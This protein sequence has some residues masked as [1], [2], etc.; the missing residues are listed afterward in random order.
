M[1][2]KVREHVRSHP[3]DSLTEANYRSLFISDHYFWVWLHFPH[4]SWNWKFSFPDGRPI[5]KQQ[6]SFVL[7]FSCVLNRIYSYFPLFLSSFIYIFISS[8]IYILIYSYHNLFISSFIYIFIY[9]Y[10]HVFT[11]AFIHIFIYLYLNLFMS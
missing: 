5:R 10:L 4:S 2:M 7:S 1:L 9:L 3:V 11:Y 6:L 8:F